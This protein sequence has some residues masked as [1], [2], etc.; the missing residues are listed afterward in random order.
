M[1]RQS[2]LFSR[3]SAKYSLVGKVFFDVKEKK[4]EKGKTQWNISEALCFKEQ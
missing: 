3:E 4:K 2:S 1:R